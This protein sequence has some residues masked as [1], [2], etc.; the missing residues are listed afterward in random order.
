MSQP[1]ARPAEAGAVHAALNYAVDTG[2]KPVAATGGKDGLERNSTTVIARHVVSIADARPLGAALSLD[3]SGF[4][5]VDQPTRVRSFLDPDELRAVYYP[6]ME[7]LIAARSGA[8]HVHIFDHTVRHGD[9][10]TRA[11][12]KLREPVKAVHNDYTDWSGPQRV[13]DF[14]PDRAAD[15]L[16]RRVAIVQVWRAIAAPVDR[17]P[18]AIADARSIAARDLVPTERRFPDRVG[19]IYQFTHN[20]AHRWFWFPDM[21]RDEALV[22]KVYDSEKDGRARWGAHTAFENPTTP[23]DAP[24]RESIEIRAFAFY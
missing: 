22:F 19:E 23:A 21:H 4:E 17:D 10:D 20:P 5:L 6:E 9:A 24:P 13:R 15:L 7:A 2:V 11:A 3:T 12:K 18:L 1:A 16:S 8:R 14:F